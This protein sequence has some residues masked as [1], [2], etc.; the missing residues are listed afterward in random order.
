[1]HFRQPE[2]KAGQSQPVRPPSHPEATCKPSSWEG[3]ATHKPPACDPQA[4]NMRPSCDLQATPERTQKADPR[5]QKCRGLPAPGAE[6]D[7][8]LARGREVW[9]DQSSAADPL[10]KQPRASSEKIA[11]VMAIPGE[12][13]IT[14]LPATTKPIN[15]RANRRY[16]S[17]LRPLE[18]ELSYMLGALHSE[19]I[20]R[21]VASTQGGVKFLG[22][23]LTRRYDARHGSCW[24]R[25]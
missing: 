24:H 21:G 3:I 19:A 10:R 9:A 22:C 17:A 1:M 4:T 7:G 12:L 5:M 14:P 13:T 8:V 20:Y 6:L 16:S 18:S 23:A 11:P 15:A 25:L 2:A